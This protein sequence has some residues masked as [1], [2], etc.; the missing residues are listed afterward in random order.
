MSRDFKEEMKKR[1]KKEMQS[2]GTLLKVVEMKGREK[3]ERGVGKRLC[4]IR[5]LG[6]LDRQLW[7]PKV[8]MIWEQSIVSLTGRSKYTNRYL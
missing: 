7:E 1:R 8:L 3:Q 2:C 6:Q 4:K 5:K